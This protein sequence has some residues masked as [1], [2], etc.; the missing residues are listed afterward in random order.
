[1][2]GSR[3][4]R[5][6]KTPVFLAGEGKSERGYGRW[7]GRLASQHDVSIALRSD[8]LNG[9]DPLHLVEEAVKKLLQIER[10]G[11]KYHYRGILLDHDLVGIDQGRDQRAFSLAKTKKF[12][13][14]WQRPTHEAFLLRHFKGHQNKSPDKKSAKRALRQVWPEYEPGMDAT[15]YE[16]KLEF[17]NL[18]VARSVEPDLDSFLTGIG[19]R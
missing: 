10:T 2:P 8:H 11:R 16:A 18:V 12:V 5:K 1:M 9:G 17:D 3:H 19:W 7:L 6:I 15:R 13:L 14:I 4:L